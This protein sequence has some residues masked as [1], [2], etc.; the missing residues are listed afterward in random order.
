MELIPT[1]AKYLFSSLVL[2]LSTTGLLLFFQFCSTNFFIAF[3]FSCIES[4]LFLPSYTLIFD[5]I[6]FVSIIY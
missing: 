5:A 1:T 2:F 6:L 4:S 3:V